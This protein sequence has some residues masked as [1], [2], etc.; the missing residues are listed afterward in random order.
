[1]TR[2][3]FT[4][5][6]LLVALVILSVSCAIASASLASFLSASPASAHELSV[7]SR[8]HRAAVDEGA[9]AVVTT[10]STDGA[11]RVLFLPDGSAVG[12]GVDPLTGERLEP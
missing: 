2:S 3:G 6:E 8:A 9:A 10:D 1:M 12:P 11:E 7:L 5:V 4:L